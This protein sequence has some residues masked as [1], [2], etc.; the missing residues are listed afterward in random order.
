MVTKIKHKSFN[1]K[2]I[3]SKTGRWPIFIFLIALIAGF[4]SIHS[5][6]MAASNNSSSTSG[7]GDSVCSFQSY[8][9]NLVATQNSTSS[10][11]TVKLVAE[12]KVR[13]DLLEAILKCGLSEVG[14]LK[15]QL[16][17][18]T[19]SDAKAQAIQSQYL[20]QLQR[21]ADFYNSEAARISGL[22][23]LGTK[24]LA[25]EVLDWKQNIYNPQGEKIMDF[26]LWLRGEKF[27]GVAQTRINDFNH[28]LKAW[29]LL[30][31]P[32]IQEDFSDAQSKLSDA[33]T[34]LSQAQDYFYNGQSYSL[35]DLTK[36]IKDSFDS[37]SGVYQDF[38]KIQSD[39]KKILPQ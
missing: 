7:N 14:D 22:G 23:I 31:N 19:T 37:I 5:P 16:E 33:Q 6:A 35:D 11:Y 38:F 15:S 26:I 28:Y 12:L 30:D 25:A 13:Q 8:L 18:E 32:Q 24:Q 39:I 2:A 4:I 20:D 34:S 29:N 17:K 3:A 27:L 10:D 21:D 9:D 36:T 1:F